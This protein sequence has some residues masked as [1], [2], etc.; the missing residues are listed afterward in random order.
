MVRTLLF[1]NGLRVLLVS[2]PSPVPH[3]GMTTSSESTGDSCAEESNS[4]DEHNSASSTTTESKATDTETE[5][6]SEE[7]MIYEFCMLL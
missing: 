6:D 7:G 4:G 1:G 2:D 3:D 5:S